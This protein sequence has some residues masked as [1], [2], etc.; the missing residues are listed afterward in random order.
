MAFMMEMALDNSRRF[1]RKR[2]VFEYRGVQ[3]MLVQDNPR[4]WADHLLTLVP[5]NDSPARDYAF[6]VAAEFVSALA[7]ETG[8]RMMLGDA[9]EQSV[10][11]DSTIHDAKPTHRTFPRIPYGGPIIG[12]DVYRIPR[13]VSEAHRIALALFREAHGSNNDYLSFL[14][15]WQVLTVEGRQG[16][17]VVNDA[18]KSARN[19][20][21]LSKDTLDSV[22]LGQH[23]SL[24][25]YLN[26]DCRNAI[27]HIKRDAG[28]RATD[29]NERDERRRFAVGVD[30]IREFA[31]HYIRERFGP[32]DYSDYLY[33]ARG[34]R[35]TPGVFVDAE[36]FQRGGHKLAY[37]QLKPNLMRRPVKR[38]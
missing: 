32:K 16:S 7:W 14:F 3:F 20:V 4:K 21:R 8:G 9:S 27:A 26:E 1:R 2:Y 6:S 34:K 22:S 24:G 11:N 35:G 17:E 38:R 25:D 10:P 12:Y 29:L 36:T 28:R 13:V 23:Q 33:L 5:D 37:P 30:V 15:F 31:A 19:R 18:F